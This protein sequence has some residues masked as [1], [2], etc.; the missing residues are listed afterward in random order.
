MPRSIEKIHGLLPKV[1]YKVEDDGIWFNVTMHYI[2]YSKSPLE[3]SVTLV[4][5]MLPG[6]AT[7][8]YKK[9]VYKGTRE[10]G[11]GFSTPRKD[12]QLRTLI[13]SARSA[14]RPYEKRFTKKKK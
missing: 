1:E 14:M 4:F 6:K 8:T 13:R 7:G 5:C 3:Q 9:S 10:S 2:D 12:P 11:A